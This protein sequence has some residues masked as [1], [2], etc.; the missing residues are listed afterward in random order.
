M[1]PTHSRFLHCQLLA[2]QREGVFDRC[3]QTWAVLHARP[4]LHLLLCLVPL[5]D[6]PHPDL[7]LLPAQHVHIC[8]VC[9]Y[10]WCDAILWCQ[11]DIIF[12]GGGVRYM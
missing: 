11:G 12:W 4:H 10:A 5:L 8:M 6:T 9:I 3:E 1:L 7:I 2:W